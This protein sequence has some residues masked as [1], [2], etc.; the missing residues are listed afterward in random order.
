MTTA[1]TK[2]PR[3]V[4]SA[5][6]ESLEARRAALMGVT[7]KKTRRHLTSDERRLVTTPLSPDADI[8]PSHFAQVT[9]AVDRLEELHQ[10]S[11][12]DT[13]G[14]GKE[15]KPIDPDAQLGNVGPASAMAA[16][17]GPPNASG[18][19]AGAVSRGTSVS[20]VHNRSASAPKTGKK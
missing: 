9:A 14:W 10:A 5:D 2:A 17:L 6:I 18:P 16:Y 8:H 12:A 4:D 19:A 20:G 11:Q 3:K 7:T 13:N 15:R 1:T